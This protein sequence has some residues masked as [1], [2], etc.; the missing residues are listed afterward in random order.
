MTQPLLE[1][2]EWLKKSGEAIYGTRPW[3]FQ[4]Q[5]NNLR[6]TT[7]GKAFYIIAL[8]RPTGVLR[9]AAPVPIVPEDQV[10][11]LGGTGN[12]LQWSEDSGTLVI[13]V[14]DAEMDLI[15]LP[16]FAFRISYGA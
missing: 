1:V 2:G 11:L 7:T 14:G 9:V 3:W 10:T 12:L 15:S 16:I 4:A 13:E 8:A 5:D 6:F